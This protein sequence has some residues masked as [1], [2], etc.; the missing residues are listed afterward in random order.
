MAGAEPGHDMQMDWYQFPLVS[1]T[2]S[3]RDLSI[4]DAHAAAHTH[5]CRMT[6]MAPVTPHCIA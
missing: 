2:L 5:L 3:I 1:Y 6:G 4:R